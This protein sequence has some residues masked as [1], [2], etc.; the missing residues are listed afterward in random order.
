M[1]TYIKYKINKIL[2]KAKTEVEDEQYLSE[3]LD[4][5]R[6]LAST[7]IEPNSTEYYNTIRIVE[8]L[9]DVGLDEV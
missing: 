3:L 4:I 7:I 9:D 6:N 2:H 8:M 5:R 1:I